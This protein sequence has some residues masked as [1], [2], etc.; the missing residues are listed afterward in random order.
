MVFIRNVFA[1]AAALVAH[2]EVTLQD[3]ISC[4][5]HAYTDIGLTI[6]LKKT[7]IM[8]Q[9]IRNAPSISTGNQTLEM[10]EKFTYFTYAVSKS[11]TLE[12][13]LS[14]HIGRSVS[15]MACLSTRE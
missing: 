13:E 7:N 4:F 3:L 9:D 5:V 6:N 10:V 2:S 8:G 11:S 14:K 12:A 1:D 15:A